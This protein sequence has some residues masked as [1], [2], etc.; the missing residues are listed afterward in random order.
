LQGSVETLFRRGGKRLHHFAE[1]LFRKLC[2][3]FYHNRM[4]FMK[5]LQETFWSL[6]PGHTQAAIA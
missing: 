3:K 5:I 1:N 2:T 6:F 4:S